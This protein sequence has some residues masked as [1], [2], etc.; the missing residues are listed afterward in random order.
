MA[1]ASSGG[2]GSGTGV[3]LGFPSTT[4]D[5]SP[6]RAD[7]LM[8]GLG[9][10]SSPNCEPLSTLSSL[11]ECSTTGEGGWPERCEPVT[12]L[13]ERELVD[14]GRCEQTTDGAR[15]ERLCD[16]E[17]TLDLQRQFLAGGARDS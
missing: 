16:P 4:E 5:G 2:C 7:E 15:R 13:T 17:P 14:F 12:D 11:T 9:G 10:S 6:K 3:L 8:L 1:V